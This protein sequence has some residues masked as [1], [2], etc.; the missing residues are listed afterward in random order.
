MGDLSV[1]KFLKEDGLHKW[2]YLIDMAAN[3]DCE[4]IDILITERRDAIS[5]EI[6]K[7]LKKGHKKE[8]L[9][10]IKEEKQV[11]IVIKEEKQTDGS[12]DHTSGSEESKTDATDPTDETTDSDSKPKKCRRKLNKEFVMFVGDE[13]RRVKLVEIDSDENSHT[14]EEC[15]DSGTDVVREIVSETGTDEKSTEEKSSNTE[16]DSN[17]TGKTSDSNSG[18]NTSSEKSNEESDRSSVRKSESDSVQEVPVEKKTIPLVELDK[19]DSSIPLFEIDKSAEKS[20][21]SEK[22]DS[23]T[24]I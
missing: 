15:T 5:A 4:A 6:E 2:R 11:P 13:R 9:I 18:E 10:V 23:T 20:D 14:L 22:S 24:K 12:C 16:S 8:D 19:S 7:D 1:D 21:S 3:D 17:T